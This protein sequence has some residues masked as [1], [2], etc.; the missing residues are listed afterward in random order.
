MQDCSGNKDCN[1]PQGPSFISYDD[2]NL[3]SKFGDS[4][5]GKRNAKETGEFEEKIGR[6]GINVRHPIPSEKFLF[7]ILDC[8]SL[9]YVL[10]D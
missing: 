3:A 9:I 1:D 4:E 7:A 10:G 2:T 6:S 8:D 5:P